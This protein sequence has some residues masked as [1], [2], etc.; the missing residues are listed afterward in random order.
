MS[1][2]SDGYVDGPFSRLRW[3]E[4]TRQPACCQQGIFDGKL[5]FV[6]ARS[7]ELAATV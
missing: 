2:Q 7:G 6:L 5:L 4:D 1:T 3:R